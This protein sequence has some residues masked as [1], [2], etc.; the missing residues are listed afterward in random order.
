MPKVCAGNIKNL[1]LRGCFVRNATSMIGVVVYTGMNTKI[2]R[3]LKK[4]PHKVSNIMKQMNKMLYSVFAF[5]FILIT[6]FAGLY[7][8]WISTNSAPHFYLMIVSYSHQNIFMLYL[9]MPLPTKPA[10]SS[11]SCLFFGSPTPT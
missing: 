9:R 11:S 8:N 1:L 3:N 2:M 10:L 5:Q 4:Q 6:L 7:I